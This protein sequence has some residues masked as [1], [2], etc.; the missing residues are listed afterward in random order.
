[1]PLK[2][3]HLKNGAEVILV[4]KTG[5]QAFTIMA[6]FPIGSRFENDRLAGASHFVE[7]MAFKGT[8]IRPDYLAITRELEAQGAHY[9]AFT[10]KDHTGYYIKINA[11][12]Q[13]LAFSVLSDMLFNSQFPAKEMVKEKKV[14]IEELKTYNDNPSFKIDLNYDELV[15]KKH[16]LGRD[17]GGSAKS[18]SNISRNELLKFYKKY[19]RPDNM[20]L[21]LA[22][23]IDNR[24]LTKNLKYFLDVKKEKASVDSIR[25]FSK[26][27]F[28]KKSLSLNE[29]VSVETKKV[30]QAHLIMGFPGLPCRSPKRFALAALIAVLS[31]GMSSRL[32]VEVREKRGLAYMIFARPTQFLDVGIFN[33]QAGLDLARLPEALKVIKNE[34]EKISKIEVSAKEL[35]D[36]KNNIIGKMALAFEDSGDLAS[37]YANN[38]WF[39]KNLETPEEVAKGIQKVTAAEVKALAKEIF[40]WNELRLALIANIKKDAVV[41][42]LK[43]F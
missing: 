30:D 43:N 28:S 35:T 24:N 37:F 26:F 23:N 1:M 13:E 39:G 7:H 2:T 9:N 18:V 34:L 15:F 36:A 41:K 16:P 14:I 17:I 32:F 4:P 42:I 20:V 19:Y 11:K 22:G 27:D 38:F 12:K 25:E 33:I 5:T 3:V 6:L 40:V 29:R 8:K 31:G 21:V 10:S